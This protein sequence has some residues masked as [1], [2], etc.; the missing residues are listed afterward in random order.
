MTEST[1]SEVKTGECGCHGKGPEFTR[2]F[3]KMF[4]PPAGAG[5]HFKQARIE[6]L[7][8]IRGLIDH[9]IEK[10]SRTAGKGTHITVE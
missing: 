4:E 10:L 3:T 9:R 1:D 8:G 2:V 7:K 6:F 5:E